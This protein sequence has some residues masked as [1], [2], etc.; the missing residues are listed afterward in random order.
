MLIL[1]LVFSLAQWTSLVQA[2]WKSFKRSLQ[3]PS[4]CIQ[5]NPM[6]RE[7]TVE[8]VGSNL[9][10]QRR[11]INLNLLKSCWIPCTTELWGIWGKVRVLSFSE[12]CMRKLNPRGMLQNAIRVQ[13][14]ICRVRSSRSEFNFI[15]GLAV[16]CL[17]SQEGLKQT[18]KYGANFLGET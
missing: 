10:K 4:L 1:S 16:C 7:F 2:N 15:E 17:K 9:L 5:L 12:D 13:T 14:P 6:V 3:Q 8:V 11:E 18:F